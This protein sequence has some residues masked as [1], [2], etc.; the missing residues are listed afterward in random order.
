MSARSRIGITV[1]GLSIAFSV[2]SFA[3]YFAFT[4]VFLVSALFGTIGAVVAMASKSRRTALVAAVFGLVPLGQLLTEHFFESEH[5]VP[6]PAATALVIAGM[7]LANY[8]QSR[9]A[10]MCPVT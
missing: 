7:A 2:S 9:R 4:P 5:L 10:S 6:L 3:I 1:A 8:A